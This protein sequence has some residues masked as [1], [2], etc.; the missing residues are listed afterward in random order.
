MGITVTLSDDDVIKWF[1]EWWRRLPE[2][3][4][5]SKTCLITEFGTVELTFEEM[6]QLMETK[7]LLGEKLIDIHRR[8]MLYLMER[9]RLKWQQK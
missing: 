1:K 6:E 4:K 9:G 7:T 3:E 8:Y 5:K 2:N